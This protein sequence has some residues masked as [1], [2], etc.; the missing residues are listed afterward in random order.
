MRRPVCWQAG[1]NEKFPYFP[2]THST[3]HV[4][5]TEKRNG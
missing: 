5:H 4:L 2:T 1:G 3:G